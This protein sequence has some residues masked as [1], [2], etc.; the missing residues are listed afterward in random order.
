MI[1]ICVRRPLQDAVRNGTDPDSCSRV[2][3]Q[4][5]TLRDEVALIRDEYGQV[6]ATIRPAF[7][8]WSFRS[9]T[10]SSTP[11]CILSGRAYSAAL[12]LP[13]SSL[14]SHLKTGMVHRPTV[15][16]SPQTLSSKTDG[17]LPIL[18]SKALLPLTQHWQMAP[19]IRARAKPSQ[20]SRSAMRK[21]STYAS[22]RLV[23]PLLKV[24][25]HQTKTGTASCF[26]SS[27]VGR[28][29]R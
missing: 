12:G 28:A 16:V 26:A 20:V 1:P 9:Q 23:H 4:A 2:L 18:G 11:Q 21:T 27:C 6:G 19:I 22:Y 13:H 25:D 5:P 29:G 14:M 10:H 8:S 15:I 7:L 24:S 17:T 3:Q